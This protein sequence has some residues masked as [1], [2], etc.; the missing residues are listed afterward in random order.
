MGGGYRGEDYL[1]TSKGMDFNDI[2]ED[3]SWKGICRRFGL[4]NGFKLH[5]RRVVCESL[6][7]LAGNRC[8]DSGLDRIEAFIWSYRGEYTKLQC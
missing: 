2:K 4:C 3:Q 7:H 8:A 6:L 5:C 1:W